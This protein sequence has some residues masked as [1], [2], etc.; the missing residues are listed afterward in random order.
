MKTDADI[1]ADIIAA[2]DRSE[3]PAEMEPLLLAEGSGYRGVLTELALE[4][5]NT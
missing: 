3:L 2:I 4:L 5:A 1:K